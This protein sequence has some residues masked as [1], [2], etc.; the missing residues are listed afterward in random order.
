MTPN[1]SAPSAAGQSGARV[2][3][4]DDDPDLRALLALAFTD[5]GYEVRAAPDGRAALEILGDWQPRIIVLDL[6]M[7]ELDGWGFRNALLGMPEAAE[8][9]LVVLSAVHTNRELNGAAAFLPKPFNL[10]QLLTTV[11]DILGGFRRS[12]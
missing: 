6:M 8:V 4:V 2:L 10:E 1:G 11:S 5:E 12:R 3:V 7:P 9:P